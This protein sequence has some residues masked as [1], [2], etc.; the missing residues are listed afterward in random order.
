MED[1]FFRVTPGDMGPNLLAVTPDDAELAAPIV[2]LSAAHPEEA[3]QPSTDDAPWSPPVVVLDS[4]MAGDTSPKV[5]EKRAIEDNCGDQER[6]RKHA[7]GTGTKDQTLGVG[8][9]EVAFR[10]GGAIEFDDWDSI[11]AN[12]PSSPSMWAHSY[13]LDRVVDQTLAVVSNS[14]KAK[15]LGVADSFRALQRYAGYSL[16]LAHEAE[17][18]FRC[19]EAH[20]QSLVDKNTKASEANL[21]L[22]VV[23]LEAEGKVNSYRDATASLHE[24]LQRTI[25]QNKDLMLA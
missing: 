22:L 23:L 13:P 17:V 12:H 25:I 9:E 15:Q 10:A 20:K 3:S 7:V 19:L 21:K 5:G 14:Y 2:P 8:E 4:L 24:D 6:P 1:L 18:E 16:V 11:L